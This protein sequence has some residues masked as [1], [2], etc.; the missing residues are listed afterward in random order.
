[1]FVMYHISNGKGVTS[2]KCDKIEANQLT[3]RVTLLSSSPHSLKLE[4]LSTAPTTRSC[5]IKPF[6]W[7]SHLCGRRQN[8]LGVVEAVPQREK[9]GAD[10]EVRMGG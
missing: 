8:Q 3:N 5:S 6:L 4:L 7:T 2:Y 10:R 1:M 9:L